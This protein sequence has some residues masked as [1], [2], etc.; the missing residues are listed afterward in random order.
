LGQMIEG[1]WTEDDIALIDASGRYCRAPAH[2]LEPIERDVLDAMAA[3]S[4]RCILVASRSCP[5]SHRVLLVRSFLR[6]QPALR[7]QFASGKRTQGYPVNCNAPW[8][9]PG[10]ARTVIWVHE[11]YSLSTPDYTGRATVPLLWDAH[12]GSIISNQSSHLMVALDNLAAVLG[13]PE[14]VTLYPAHLSDDM[15]KREGE[16]HQCLANGVYRAGF[17]TSQSAYDAACDGVFDYLDWLD[18]RLSGNRFFFGDLLTAID[19][20]LF[21]CLI[22]FDTVYATHFRCT[23]HRLIEYAHIWTY[24]RRL[25]AIPELARDVDFDEI[26]RGYFLNDGDHNPHG[27]VSQA[28]LLDWSLPGLKDPYVELKLVD[29][30]GETRGYQQPMQEGKPC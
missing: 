18:L 29:R 6:L 8:P 7:V 27:I 17:A 15:H 13:G 24:L 10:N 30:R 4:D 26:R 1:K 3:M 9:V 20:S 16:M 28:P 23:R 11:L 21:S 14:A 2:F 5:W 19:L 12:E 25:F 22:R